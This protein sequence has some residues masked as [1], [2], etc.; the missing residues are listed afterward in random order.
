MINLYNSKE[1][2]FNNNG[3]GSLR[4]TIKCEVTE[5]LNGEFTVD[6]EY[7]KNCKY[8]NYIV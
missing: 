3:I 2:N 6:F 7:P 8:S 4:D 1:T 5:E